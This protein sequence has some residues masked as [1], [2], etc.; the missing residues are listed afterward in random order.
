MYI[1]ASTL[2]IGN[3]ENRSSLSAPSDQQIV[4]WLQAGDSKGASWLHRAYGKRICGLIW[5]VLGPDSEYEDV[6]HEVYVN[7]FSSIHRL[8]E[9]ARLWSWLARVTTNTVRQEIRKRQ[10]YRRKKKMLADNSARNPHS[11]EASLSRDICVMFSKLQVD[12]RIAFSLRYIEGY[13]LD[14]VAGACGCSLATIKRRLSKAKKHLKPLVERM[15]QKI[16]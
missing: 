4:A 14:E 7:V 3:L 11:M 8:R 9:P 10:S 16:R 12:Q 15:E 5:R 13:S 2:V 6:V 1:K